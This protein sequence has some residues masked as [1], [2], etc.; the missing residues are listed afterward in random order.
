MQVP[1]WIGVGLVGAAAV[2]G[3]AQQRARPARRINV[4]S[5]PILLLLGWNL[6]IYLLLLASLAVRRAAASTPGG[7]ASPGASHGLLMWVAERAT[8]LRSGF[9]DEP[10]AVTRAATAAY[11]TGWRRVAAPLR[12]RARPCAPRTSRPRRSRRV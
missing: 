9:A 5:V 11:L 2:I 7:P 3:V 12:H 4:L 8:R 6:F 10:S 1:L